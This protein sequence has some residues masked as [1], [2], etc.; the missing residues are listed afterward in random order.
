MNR[1]NEPGFWL[2]RENEPGILIEPKPEK[3]TR[4]PIEPGKWTRIFIELFAV[5]RQQASKYLFARRPCL[6]SRRPTTW[7]F[8]YVL[9]VG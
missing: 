4:I 8:D 1:E 2:N 9:P 7:S 3:W 5:A 6:I